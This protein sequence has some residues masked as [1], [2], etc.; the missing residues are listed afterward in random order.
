M[1]FKELQKKYKE[2]KKKA[3]HYKKVATKKIDKFERSKKGKAL[4]RLSKRAV[5]AYKKL[6]KAGNRAG[7]GYANLL[8]GSSK[9]RGGG[10]FW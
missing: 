10:G 5:K 7:S 2:A 9:G 6:D 4:K 8:G 3:I 1:N